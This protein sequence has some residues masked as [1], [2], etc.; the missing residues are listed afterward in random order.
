MAKD[1]WKEFR[2]KLLEDPATRAAYEARKPAYE[3]AIQLAELRRQ[4]GLSQA[5]LARRAGMTQSEVARIEAAEASPTFD[6]MARLLAAAE[7]D[8]EITFKDEG[9]K[10]VRL[11]MVL[12]GSQLAPRSRR[13]RTPGPAESPRES[14]HRAKG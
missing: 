7:A 5:A 1:D 9:G 14:L 2:A 6:T 3:F 10:V 11:P 4:R 13:G 8:L 12:K